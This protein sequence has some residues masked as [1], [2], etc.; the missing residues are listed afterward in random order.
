MK[1]SLDWLSDYLSPVPPAQAAADA[2]MNAG[3]PVEFIVDG[4]SKDGGNTQVL[5]VEVTSNR[6]DCFCHVGLARELSAVYGGAFSA[7]RVTLT[8]SATPAGSLTKV[9]IQ[10]PDCP[11]YS[12]RIIRGVKIGPSPDWLQRRLTAI[13]L[14][15]I[16]NVVDIT[17]YVLMELGQPL[18]AFDFDKLGG[19]RI[20]V[21]RA[22]TGEKLLAID[23]KEY[24]LTPSMLVI[25]DE[26]SPAA[27]AGVM[28]GKLSEVTDAT[29][30]ILLES[31][32]FDQLSI[33]TTS[34]ALGLKSD[35]SYRF[36][37]GIDPAAAESASR[38]AAQLILQLAGGELTQGVVTA[39]ANPIRNVQATMRFKRYQQV[40]G[41]PIVPERAI[42]ILSALGFSPWIDEG[43]APTPEDDA[44]TTRI[45][46]H[47]LDVDREIDLIE[48]IA[49]VDGYNRVPTLSRIAH[50]VTPEAPREKAARAL[51]AAMV[52]AG[53][54]EAVTVTFIAE[55]EAAPFADARQLIH[56][57]HGGWKTDVLRP[58]LIPSLLAARRTNQYA[59][60]ADARLFETGATFRQ[61]G[62][63]L[64]KPP[65]ETRVLT[66]IAGDL[67]ALTALLPLI[68]DRLN[69]AAR[70]AVTPK[71]LPFFTR[72]TA[73]EITLTHA[74][75]T[76]AIGS[77]GLLPSDLQ[78][79]YDLRHPVAALELQLEP[80]LATFQPVRRAAPVPRFPGITRD[81]SL[82]LDE[83]TRW[84]DLHAALAAAHLASLP[85]DDGIQF[86]TTFR[87]AQ[88]GAGK[89]SLTL[90]L[91]FR[92]P[93]RTLTSEEVDTEVQKAVEVLKTKFAA[94]LRG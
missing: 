51:R 92:D 4:I 1:I 62:E 42:A 27:I 89:K 82:V 13:G 61:I 77:A 55:T 5:D 84:S 3:L 17:N 71:E 30:T 85:P 74:G 90:T 38:R 69:P 68:I 70:T 11:Y 46:S 32:R 34:R 93:N 65:T 25:A 73:G 16:N 79:K 56:P 23:G 52:E 20:V 45:P 72:G 43:N 35:S 54:S 91:N 14:R 18:H 86:V 36:E 66:A 29:T 81:L 76:A 40:I 15:P 37:R 59:G 60:I 10:S 67:S 33:R 48:E 41:V 6:T 88:I 49:R 80:L 94:V 21:R 53:F 50:A 19:K 39:G 9:E 57:Q 26:K 83:A 8:E 63:A 12:A 24:P 47:R 44:L 28:G 87:N 64:A 31:A 2:L 78:K 22:A 75:T 58:S 7:P